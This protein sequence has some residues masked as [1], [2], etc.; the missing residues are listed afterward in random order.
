[1]NMARV[2]SRR[3]VIGSL[4]QNSVFCVL[5]VSAGVSQHR[6]SRHLFSDL[7]VTRF[8]AE[9]RT[10]AL[11]D[12]MKHTGTRAPADRRVFMRNSL[13]VLLV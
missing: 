6:A 4:L 13:I 2:E 9:R 3:P 12:E 7:R 10:S 11:K 1:M 8:P 5:L